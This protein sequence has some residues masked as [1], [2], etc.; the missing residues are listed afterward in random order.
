MLDSASDCEGSNPSPS[1]TR[2]LPLKGRSMIILAGN[3]VTCRLNFKSCLTPT[4]LFLLS[5]VE[6]IGYHDIFIRD[7]P[8]LLFM[9]QAFVFWERMRIQMPRFIILQAFPNPL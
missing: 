6:E 9:G 4:L 3:A 2:L 7:L 8:F 1:A 5:F